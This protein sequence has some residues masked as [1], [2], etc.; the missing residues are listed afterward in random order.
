VSG[1]WLDIGNSTTAGK[2][3]D[4]VGGGIVTFEDF[5]ALAMNKIKVWMWTDRLVLFI[6]NKLAADMDLTPLSVPLPST[7]YN[8]VQWGRTNT[9]T[10]DITMTKISYADT[11]IQGVLYSGA[12]S[13]TLGTYTT[14]ASNQLDLGSNKTILVQSPSIES[15]TWSDNDDLL[16]VPD[17]LVV[18]DL[19]ST[20]ST[21]LIQPEIRVKKDGEDWGEWVAVVAGE[22]YGRY[23]DRRLRGILD[24]DTSWLKVTEWNWSS[25]MPDIIQSAEEV[26]IAITGTAVTFSRPF[27]AVPALSPA[28]IEGSNSDTIKITSLTATGFTAFYIDSTGSAITGKMSYIAKGY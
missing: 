27:Q 16:S 4:Y 19:L 13:T 7:A 5:N 2:I 1:I 23:F 9:E 10:T 21:S 14:N 24:S 17:L 25:D 15:A 8:L 18:T 3:T 28:A 26:N 11:D 6:N 22:Y 20:E 12:I